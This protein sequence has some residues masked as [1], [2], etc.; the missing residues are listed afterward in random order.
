MA[1]GF[2]N[3]AINCDHNRTRRKEKEDKREIKIEEKE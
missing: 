3:L 1:E 2:S